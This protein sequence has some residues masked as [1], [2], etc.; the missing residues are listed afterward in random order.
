MN[1]KYAHLSST[2][3]FNP[4][5]IELNDNVIINIQLDCWIKANQLY[6]S[7]LQSNTND[8]LVRVQIIRLLGDSLTTLFGMNYHGSDSN[9]PSLLSYINNY[10]PNS[11][12]WNLKTDNLNLYNEFIEFDNFHKNAIKHFDKRKISLLSNLTINKVAEYIKITK[13]IWI[14]FL[15]KHFNELAP[16]ELLKYFK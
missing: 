13:N 6:Q 8:I 16:D 7:H 1:D 4:N 3:S 9:T 10:F 11:M 12:N 14:W 2:G 5:V 15:N